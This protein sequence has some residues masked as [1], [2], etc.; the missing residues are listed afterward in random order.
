MCAQSDC[1][2]LAVEVINCL[3]CNQHLFACC[4]HQNSL[5]VLLPWHLEKSAAKIFFCL[6]EIAILIFLAAYLT[7]KITLDQ[8]ET[9][10]VH[11]VKIDC[12]EK[13]EEITYTESIKEEMFCCVPVWIFVE[14]ILSECIYKH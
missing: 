14:L 4:S 6:P 1:V 13:K 12:F 2:A 7:D 10:L 9:K 3:P 5:N 8:F 11:N